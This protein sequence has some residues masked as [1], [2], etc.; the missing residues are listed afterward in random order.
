MEGYGGLKTIEALGEH[1]TQGHLL[2]KIKKEDGFYVVRDDVFLYYQRGDELIKAP[3]TAGQGTHKGFIGPELMFGITM[4]D[5]FEEPVLLIKTAWGGK[6][7]YCDFRPPKAGNPGYAIPGKPRDMGASF[8]KM[9]EEVHQCLDR[10]DTHFTLFKG[11]PYELCGF[12]WFQGWS[13]PP[14]AKPEA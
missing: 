11:R 3:L 13:Q 12:V 4:G 14:P 8:R 1:P 2:K 9:I 10:L 6:D 7:L 5:Y